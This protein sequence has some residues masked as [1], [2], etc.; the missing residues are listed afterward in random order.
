MPRGRLLT[1]CK[2]WY[3]V[4]RRQRSWAQTLAPLVHTVLHYTQ[5][6][7]LYKRLK[8]AR[9]PSFSILVSDSVEEET[10]FVIII[11]EHDGTIEH[12]LGEAT[13]T[14][15]LSTGVV[16]TGW[17]LVFGLNLTFTMPIR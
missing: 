2:T 5:Y 7:V 10:L 6:S 12:Y 15:D 16:D 11:G 3:S 17:R 4:E 9:D 1:K 13:N 8:H 14:L